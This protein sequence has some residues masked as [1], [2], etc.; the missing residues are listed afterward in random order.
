M[1]GEPGGSLWD[2][3][4][5]SAGV[6][7]GFSLPIAKRLNIDFTIAVGYT[8]CNYHIYRPEDDCYVKESTK[9]LRAILP[10]KAEVSIVWLLGRGN[11]NSRKGGE[12]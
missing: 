10:A 11:T 3:L 7:Y 8:D 4:N 9:H 12:K 1:G 2:K 6:E 5:W